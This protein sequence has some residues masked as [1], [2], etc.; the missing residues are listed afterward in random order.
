MYPALKI[1]NASNNNEGYAVIKKGFTA[2]KH[3][4]I[5]YTDGDLQFTVSELERLVKAQNTQKVDIVNG[6][7]LHRNDPRLRVFIGSAY[8]LLCKALFLLPISDIDCDFRLIRAKYVK[9]VTF[10]AK[11]SSI[12][13]ELIKKL[14][15]LGATFYEVPVSHMHRQYGNS[16]YSALSLLHEKIIGDLQLWWTFRNLL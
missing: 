11:K 14:E 8:R 12:L 3:E 5:F 1:V 7:R 4:W 2:A 13:P 16:N 10:T 6:Y 15:F 9:Q